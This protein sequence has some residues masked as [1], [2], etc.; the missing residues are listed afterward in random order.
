[1]QQQ[2]YLHFKNG[3]YDA[4]G[5]FLKCHFLDTS[6]VKIT[7][8]EDRLLCEYGALKNVLAGVGEVNLSCMHPDNA[9]GALKKY[10]LSGKAVLDGKQLEDL[11]GKEACIIIHIQ[12]VLDYSENELQDISM[13]SGQKKVPVLID[14]GRSLNEMGSIDKTYGISPI[15]VLEDMGFL[16]RE[17]TLLGGN[18]LDKDDLAILSMYGTK[19]CLT[20]QSDMLKGR[21]FVN[22]AMIKNSGIEVTFASDDYPYV[23]MLSEVNWACGQTV[24]LL[25]DRNAISRT[26]ILGKV[27]TNPTKEMERMMLSGERPCISV[28]K[29][30]KERF[31]A[32]EKELIKKIKEK[33]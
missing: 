14:Y 18:Y 20:P 4:L 8:E 16:D 15:R 28:S 21:G 31:L 32:I 29:E 5:S 3:Y 26:E 6:Q 13:L 30:L 7:D 24:N 22:L 9:L 1:M 10:S 17:C 33:I 12:S 27:T 11:D 2:N 23:D 19:L 25:C